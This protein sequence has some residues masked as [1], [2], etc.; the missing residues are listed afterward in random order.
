MSWEES[1]VC[2][3]GK[4]RKRGKRRGGGRMYLNGPAYCAERAEDIR[5]Y[6][7]I[8]AVVL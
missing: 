5:C 4:G 3:N 8:H 2:T 6:G 1:R 7:D